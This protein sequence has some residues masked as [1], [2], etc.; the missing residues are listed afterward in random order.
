MALTVIQPVEFPFR[1]DLFEFCTEELQ[2]ELAPN[3]AAAQVAEEEIL[4]I[5]A[6]KAKASR[7][8]A[9]QEEDAKM[10]VET[11]EE[12]KELVLK[13]DTGLYD[14]VAVVSH[15][16]RSAEG[17]HYVAWVKYTEGLNHFLLRAIH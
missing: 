3:R 13:N 6:A 2:A 8:P 5:K 11:A 9:A 15:R 1:L 12:K 7:G 17:G 16:G 10:E 14:L 4:R